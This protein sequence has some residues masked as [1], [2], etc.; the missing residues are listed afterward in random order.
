M[1]TYLKLIFV[2]SVVIINGCVSTKSYIGI[3]PVYPIP[4][5]LFGAGYLYESLHVVKSLQPTLK[6]KMLATEGFSYDLAIWERPK[7]QRDLKYA[8]I[9]YNDL[10]YYVE[11]IKDAQHK[12]TSPLLPDTAYMWTVR[13]RKGK[14]IGQWAVYKATTTTPGGLWEIWGIPYNFKTPEK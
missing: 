1:K 4:N 13:A 7:L 8:G 3:E 2:L 10:D 6:W 12:V 9:E 11:N 14:E 5:A